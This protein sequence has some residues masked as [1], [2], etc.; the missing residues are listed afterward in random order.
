MP[1]DRHLIDLNAELAKFL[2]ASANQRA[3]VVFGVEL[4]ESLFN[5][6]DLHAFDIFA[7]RFGVAREPKVTLAW[8][9]SVDASDNLEQQRIV[10]DARGH[11]AAVVDRRLDRHDTGIGHQIPQWAAGWRT[12]PA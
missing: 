10:G 5:D 1:W 3:N 4:L 6:G 11:R 2:G 9:E 8:V 7:E 12:E